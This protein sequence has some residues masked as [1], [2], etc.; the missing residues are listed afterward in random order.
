MYASDRI[1]IS[2]LAERLVFGDSATFR[3]EDALELARLLPSGQ[4]RGLLSGLLP[5]VGVKA[6]LPGSSAAGFAAGVGNVAVG[7]GEISFDVDSRGRRVVR[8]GQWKICWVGRSIE[9]EQVM[10]NDSDGGR[11]ARVEFRRGEPVGMSLLSP[12]EWTFGP[13][14]LAT[15]Q[16]QKWKSP[17]P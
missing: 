12:T 13:F 15:G 11:T 2:S 3:R 10:A 8:A 7:G 17:L 14:V 4:G 5:S 6:N 9:I 16:F 1:A